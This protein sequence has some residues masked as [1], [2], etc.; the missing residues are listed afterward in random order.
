MEKRIRFICSIFFVVSV[1]LYGQYAFGEANLNSMLTPYLSEYELPAVAAAVVKDGKIVASGASGVRRIGT[2]TPVTINDRFHI[3]S[4]TKAFT[5]LLAAM[6]VEEG[7]LTWHTTIAEV[8]PELSEK[9]NP[10][11]AKITIE[12]LLSHTSGIPSDNEEVFNMYR[13]AM[14]QEG[15]LD[16]MR[17]WLTKEWVR[18]PLALPSGSQ[19]AYS[20]MGYTIAGAMIER[21]AGMT[22]DELTIE[23]IFV[24]LRLKTAGLG[25]QASLGKID[26]PIGHK[27]VDGKIKAFLSGPNGDAPSLIGPA[28]IAH[29]SIIDF[30]RW[31]S[32]NAGEGRRKPNLVKAETLKRLHTPIVTMPAKKDAPPG[33]PPGGKYGL[34]WGELTVDWAPQPLLYH[35]GSNGMNLAHIWIDTKNDFAMVLTTNIGGKKADDALRAIAGKLYKQYAKKPGR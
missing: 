18:R 2:R 1:I 5:A 9:M 23:R 8:F 35:G 13:E 14:A 21:R 26:A 6:L 4:D 31:A 28:G 11:V 17:Y 7:R 29:M 15:N 20:N 33:T 16:E 30:A 19:F 10:D 27:I 34:G 3:G 32:W 12:Q 24:P 25:Q 22:W